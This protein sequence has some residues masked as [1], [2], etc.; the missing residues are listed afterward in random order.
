[1][2]LAVMVMLG[3]GASMVFRQ[4]DEADLAELRNAATA[5]SQAESVRRQAADRV[6]E[7]L[8]EAEKARV[9]AMT[10]ARAAA[11]AARAAPRVEEAGD[12]DGQDDRNGRA[13]EGRPDEVANRIVRRHSAAF[14]ACYE[15]ALKTA[16]PD[17]KG[18]VVLRVAVAPSG[19]VTHASIADDTLGDPPTADCIVRRARAMRFPARE[20]AVTLTLPLVFAAEN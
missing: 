13:D 14:R 20:D 1:M 6:A 16:S 2:L 10:A 4:L 15:R 8:A 7:A 17:L 11:A 19:A 12:G 18:R 3:V 5:A 9:E